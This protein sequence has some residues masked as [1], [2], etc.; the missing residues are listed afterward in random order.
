M[1]TPEAIRI[2]PLSG[3]W[4]ISIDF[5]DAYFQIPTQNQSRKYLR[6]H[7]LDQSYQFKA[8]QFGLST[9]P[10]EST[11]MTKDVKLIALQK[12]IRIHQYLDDLLIRARS[13]KASLQHTQTLVVP[14]KQQM[15]STSI[16]I[17]YEVQEQTNCSVC[18]TSSRSP[19]LGSRCTSTCHRSIWT[20][21][22]SDQLTSWTKWWRSCRTTH[23]ESF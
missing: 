22:P 23:A 12:G 3:E 20:L 21:M 9:A 17:C 18:I 14:D 7:I 6:F 15:V 8:L 16:A 13:R 5:M 10:M 1:G 2:S 11:V 4:V 19:G